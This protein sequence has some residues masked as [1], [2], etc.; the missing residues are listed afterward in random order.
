MDWDLDYTGS[1]ICSDPFKRVLDAGEGVFDSRHWNYPPL[2]QNKPDCLPFPRSCMA[3]TDLVLPPKCPMELNSRPCPFFSLSVN[4]VLYSYDLFTSAKPVWGHTVPRK[5]RVY[6]LI[7]MG[8]P[9]C[10]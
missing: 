1:V 3:P 10:W 7:L 6:I 5:W 9:R 2:S 4:V 8:L